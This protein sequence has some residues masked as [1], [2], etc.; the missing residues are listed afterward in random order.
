MKRSQGLRR[1]TG[2]KRSGGLQRSARLRSRAKRHRSV[3]EQRLMAAWKAGVRKKCSRCGASYRVC[4]HHVL[5]QREVERAARRRHLDW[6]AYL[7]DERNRFSA[8]A[9]CH[10]NHHHTVG[11][12]GRLELGVVEREAP[13]VR[14]FARELGLEHRLERLYR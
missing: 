9:A 3:R 8:C 4:G 13:D 10:D 6:E 12:D 1:G 5:E 2:L 14:E 7:W 11:H